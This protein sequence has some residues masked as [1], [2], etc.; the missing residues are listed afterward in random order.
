MNAPELKI[1]LPLSLEYQKKKKLLLLKE[2][3]R[4]NVK[5]VK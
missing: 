1:S 3:K 5:F 4:M 2:L